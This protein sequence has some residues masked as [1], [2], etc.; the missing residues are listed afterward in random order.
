MKGKFKNR[1]GFSL[2]EVILSLAILG[3][4][5][6]MVVSLSNIGYRHSKE[7]L[8]RT[9]ALNIGEAQ[10]SWLKGLDYEKMAMVDDDYEENGIVKARTYM[11]GEKEDGYSLV[12]DKTGYNVSTNISRQERKNSKGE[13][14]LSGIKNIDIYVEAKSLNTGEV[15]EYIKLNTLISEEHELDIKED[16]L[17]RFKVHYKGEGVPGVRVTIESLG[18]EKKTSI[19]DYEGYV[20]Y[21]FDLKSNREE[22]LSRKYTAEVESWTKGEIMAKPNSAL[23]EAW[24]FQ[25]NGISPQ[26]IFSLDGEKI[27]DENFH[28]INVDFPGY[29]N[30]MTKIDEKHKLHIKPRDQEG[31][32]L[33][34][35]SLKGLKDLK[36]WRDWAYDISIPSLQSYNLYDKDLNLW[37]GKFSDGESSNK[38]SKLDLYL[39]Y[40]L[41]TEEYDGE[42][43]L[44]VDLIGDDYILYLGEAKL[45]EG[46]YRI[47]EVGGHKYRMFF[48]DVI[49]DLDGLE[50][51][52]I[53]K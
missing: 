35:I 48:G 52:I 29:I 37:D 14:I 23:K 10:M 20:S 21:L 4:M 46:D 42:E 25:L 47:E 33:N 8:K 18:K 44:E 28:Y 19:S 11:N 27:S 2:I 49:D 22:I 16:A 31:L 32:D 41:S 39:G 45:E 40:E 7:N 53:F 5:S 6:L 43:G 26:T 36:F 3:T 50:L 38:V 51:K 1:G 17:I 24:I 13:L 15:L 34:N 12:V 30:L 9:M